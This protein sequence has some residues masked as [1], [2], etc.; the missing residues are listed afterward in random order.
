MSEQDD[1]VSGLPI[2]GVRTNLLV[3]IDGVIEAVYEQSPSIQGSTCAAVLQNGDPLFL[4]GAGDRFILFFGLSSFAI[5]PLQT[6]SLVITR[7]KINATTINLPKLGQH[8]NQP[9]LSRNQIACD[10][11]IIGL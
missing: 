6:F 7:Y 2:A 3:S 5:E 11:H 9:A 4:K 1:I 8:P 10:H